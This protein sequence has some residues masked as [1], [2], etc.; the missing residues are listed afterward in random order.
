MTTVDSGRWTGLTLYQ[1]NYTAKLRVKKAQANARVTTPGVVL[2]QSF[3]ITYV[4]PVQLCH[5]L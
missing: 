3:Q 4:P 1:L 2:Q 5:F